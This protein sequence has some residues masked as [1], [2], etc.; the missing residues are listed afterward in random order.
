MGRFK[1]TTD[2]NGQIV[3]YTLSGEGAQMKP[4][5]EMLDLDLETFEK[6]RKNPKNFQLEKKGGKL[7][8]K[9][10]NNDNTGSNGPTPS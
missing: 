7:T 2:S 5:G 1:A 4:A 10:K 3:L 9:D 6:I 8:I